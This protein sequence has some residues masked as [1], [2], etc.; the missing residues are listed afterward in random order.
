MSELIA[1]MIR[2]AALAACT[3]VAIYVIARIIAWAVTVSVYQAQRF[4]ER[5]ER[6]RQQ[7][8]NRED[9]DE[10]G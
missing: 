9:G 2:G 3:L 5:Q 7:Q 1:N 8:Q 10:Q 6:R 4:A